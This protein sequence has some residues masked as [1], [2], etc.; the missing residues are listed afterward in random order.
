MSKKP[1]VADMECNQMEHFDLKITVRWSDLD[2]NGHVRH[3]AY[4]DYAAQARIAFLHKHGFNIEWMNR[5][6]L[7]PVLFREEALFYREL[8]SG[9][10]LCVDVQLSALSADHRKWCMRHRIMR[11]TTLCAELHAD[12]AWLDLQARRLACPPDELIETLTGLVRTEDFQ[13]FV[14]SKEERE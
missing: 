7:G 13:D 11:G 4:Y 5:N 2:P 6:N 14:R 12:G 1:P 3:S 9:D 8:N 10:D